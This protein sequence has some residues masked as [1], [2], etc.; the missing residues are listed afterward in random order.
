MAAV[1]AEAQTESGGG[2][3]GG[4]PHSI[5]VPVAQFIEDVE[6][7]LSGRDPEVVVKAL[8]ERYQQ[9]KLVEARLLQ[10]RVRLQAKL[11]DIKKARDTVRLLCERRD[12]VA[13]GASGAPEPLDADFELAD[14]VFARARVAADVGSV[15]LWLGANVMLEYPLDEALTLLQKNL[16]NCEANLKK[17]REETLTLKDS[18][19]IT[20]VSIARIYNHDVVRRKRAAA[21]GE[22]GG[23]D[24]E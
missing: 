11:P 6:E 3:G 4:H 1:A 23:G 19:T 18:I 21:K 8:Q 9:Y 17:N 24:E 5:T 20:E 7:F 13:A 2:G 22:G 15:H 10:N 14:G 16:E 12:A